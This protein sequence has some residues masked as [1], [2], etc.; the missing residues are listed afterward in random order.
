MVYPT[1]MKRL[2]ILIAALA[3][4][5][6]T[7]VQNPET[8]DEC[9]QMCAHGRDKL[10]GCEFSRPAASG[11]PCEDICAN[12]RKNGRVWDAQC[13]LDATSCTVADEC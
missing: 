4:S 1:R 3:L 9:G 13:I 8:L 2:S 10:G 11:A 12:S 5:T 7:P 6:C